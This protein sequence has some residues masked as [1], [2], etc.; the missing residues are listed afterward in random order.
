MRG[1]RSRR[2][3]TASHLTSLSV[4]PLATWQ[5]CARQGAHRAMD[6]PSLHA[7][8]AC[9]LR[10]HTHGY[11]CASVQITQSAGSGDDVVGGV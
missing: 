6:R 8:S 7:L 4:C 9:V 3:L 2:Q 1:R 5:A 11:A 10:A